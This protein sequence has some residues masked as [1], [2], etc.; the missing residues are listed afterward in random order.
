[1]DGGCVEG[2][3]EG[4]GVG[5]GGEG[6]RFKKDDGYGWGMHCFVGVGVGEKVQG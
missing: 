4:C 2:G 1:M 3:R 5:V 6:G